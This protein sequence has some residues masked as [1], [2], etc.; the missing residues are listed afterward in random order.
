MKL[1]LIFSLSLFLFNTQLHIKGMI[2][3]GNPHNIEIMGE[4][5][6]DIE[7]HYDQDIVVE[8]G[9]PEPEE[10]DHFNNEKDRWNKIENLNGWEVDSRKQ[11]D[12]IRNLFRYVPDDVDPDVINNSKGCLVFAVIHGTGFF[13]ESGNKNKN[14]F[15]AET[16]EFRGILH[17]AKEYLAQYNFKRSV[18]GKHKKYLHLFSFCW[19]GH[20]TDMLGRKPAAKKLAYYLDTLYPNS[21][22]VTLA[23]SHGCTIV[24]WASHFLKKFKEKNEIIKSNG[25]KKPYKGRIRTIIHF[26]SPCK[27][28]MPEDKKSRFY[29][30]LGKLFDK[31]NDIMAKEPTDFDQLFAFYSL[32]DWTVP[33][34]VIDLWTGGLALT[35]TV[36]GCAAT[37][38]CSKSE[39]EEIQKYV[40]EIAGLTLY[41]S[42]VTINSIFKKV[43]LSHCY[44]DIM[45]K[46]NFNNDMYE[47]KGPKVHIE[48]MVNRKAI[49]HSSNELLKY[50]GLSLQHL[51][52]YFP[53]HISAS[54]HF[55]LNINTEQVDEHFI[56]CVLKKLNKDNADGFKGNLTLTTENKY[57]TYIGMPYDIKAKQIKKKLKPYG[58]Y[59]TKN[60]RIELTPEQIEITN[61]EQKE[62]NHAFY[63]L[64][65]EYNKIE[66][67]ISDYYEERYKLNENDKY[68]SIM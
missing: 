42:V 65:T 50:F 53:I 32:N 12:Y 46:N 18:K 8:V 15:D 39:N 57:Y 1:K 21:P 59:I 31:A 33:L 67:P 44:E 11:Q 47:I 17:F 23:H 61:I 24:N 55:K 38:V 58:I 49:G 64:N 26:A 13:G 34:A 43:R 9:N 25:E 14:Y 35:F 56:Q 62:V 41:T 60:K 19:N 7:N 63:A 68:C 3:D 5:P 54:A 16:Q 36:G 28:K 22:I 2:F 40:K 27:Q 10:A 48:T 6:N 4:N 29:N 30:P 20:L 51:S 37:Y 45:P 52:Q 66:R